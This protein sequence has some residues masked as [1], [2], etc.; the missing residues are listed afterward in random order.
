MAVEEG[1]RKS[2]R[3]A[4]K[5]GGKKERL[6]E[7]RRE[8]EREIGEGGR[9]SQD[10]DTCTKTDTTASGSSQAPWDTFRSTYFNIII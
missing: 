2:A 6:W 7:R 4:K 9:W 1:K 8:R 3:R 10:L 5:H